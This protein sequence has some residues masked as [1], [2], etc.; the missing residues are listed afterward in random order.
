M[1][2]VLQI[3]TNGVD[4]GIDIQRLPTWLLLIVNGSLA[5]VA[6]AA[7]ASIWLPLL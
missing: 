7:L 5:L 3:L 4:H 2:S 1:G 6:L